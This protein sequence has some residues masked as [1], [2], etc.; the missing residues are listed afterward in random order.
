MYL[1]QTADNSA[2][3]ACIPDSSRLAHRVNK[4]Y[5]LSIEWN[6]DTPKSDTK[7]YLKK[8]YRFY[9]AIKAIRSNEMNRVCLL[10]CW[11]TLKRTSKPKVMFILYKL[12]Q[13]A[14]KLFNIKWTSTYW[15]QI[16]Y[17]ARSSK[18]M[19]SNATRFNTEPI[20]TVLHTQSFD[21]W[22]SAHRYGNRGK[23]T[24]HFCCMK[25][26]VWV[27]SIHPCKHI[28]HEIRIVDP[29]ITFPSVGWMFTP[30]SGI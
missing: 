13:Q 8:S 26:N 4:R 7:T 20:A 11:V 6:S 25:W 5:I 15:Q 27:Y 17:N 9:Y 10:G 19:P 2:F 24:V 12:Q 3:N 14:D 21:A 22:N 16:V 1:V 23:W 29:M 30:S 18:C 28:Q